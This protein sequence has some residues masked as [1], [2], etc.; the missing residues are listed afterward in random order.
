MATDPYEVLGVPKT[1]TDKQIRSAFVKLAKKSHPDLNPG[2]KQAEERFK[3]I[4]AANDLLSDPE[5]RA[6]FDR[7]EID[8]SGQEKAPEP[9]PGWGRYRQH[10]ESPQGGF[11]GSSG[12][13][14]EGDLGDIIEEMLRAQ[15][16]GGRRSRAGQ[17]YQY[18]LT[19]PF[20]DAV[21]GGTQ[22]LNLP[23]GGNLDV[24]IPV[25]LESGQ[26]LRLR[27][28]GAPGDP[29]GDALIE[30]EV[31]PHPYF[32]REGNDILCDLPVTV[33]E[34]MLGGKIT[35]PTIGGTVAMNIPAG[36]ETGTRLRLRGRGVPAHG[37]AAAGD[38][39]V[40]LKL[41]LGG[42]DPSLEKFLRERQDAPA[43]NPRAGM[44]DAA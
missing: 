21:R 1:A 18:R 15:G 2:D 27:A 36:S 19:V 17:D 11:Y 42:P 20:L 29:P 3:A 35:V 25:G 24:R 5:K 41:V 7:G 30:V 26:T 22:R 9:P 12:F 33:A 4:N 6:R 28:K 14:D 13:A 10:A 40:V 39:Y 43:H 8:A 37:G 31:A 38:A 34:A 44:E 32:R 23:E 16:R